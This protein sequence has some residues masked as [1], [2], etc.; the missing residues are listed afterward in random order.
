VETIQNR[1]ISVLS[2]HFTI[3]D[4]SYIRLRK[5][6]AGDTNLHLIEYLSQNDRWIT[7]ENGMKCDFPGRQ[8]PE[9]GPISDA[10]NIENQ[11]ELVVAEIATPLTKFWRFIYSDPAVAHL[12]KRVK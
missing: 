4:S 5:L 6:K 10:L 3:P 7:S 2:E 9:S 11:R 1:I 12:Y 8:L